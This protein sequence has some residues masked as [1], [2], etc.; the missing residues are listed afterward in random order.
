MYMANTSGDQYARKV[1]LHTTNCLPAKEKVNLHVS[2]K[3]VAPIMLNNKSIGDH[4]CIYIYKF[5]MLFV[6][7][8]GSSAFV[9]NVNRC[10]TVV[11]FA[12]R[13]VKKKEK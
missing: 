3:K 1:S 4:S 11:P 2:Q 7:S 13:W 8:F 12:R 6:C 5:L 10:D 9:D